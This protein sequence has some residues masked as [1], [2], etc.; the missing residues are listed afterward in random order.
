M[1]AFTTLIFAPSL[2]SYALKNISNKWSKALLSLIVPLTRLCAIIAFFMG[3]SFVSLKSLSWLSIRLQPYLEAL[4]QWFSLGSVYPPVTF[5]ELVLK[6]VVAGLL[7]GIIC[8]NFFQWHPQDRQQNLT[9]VSATACCGLGIYFVAKD[10]FYFCQ[11]ATKIWKTEVGTFFLKSVLGRTS[12]LI[13]CTKALSNIEE[14]PY[15]MYFYFFFV[16]VF[17]VYSLAFT[18]T[19]N[20][21]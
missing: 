11:I 6:C 10:T 3:S 5:M 20:I 15:T 21:F 18:A 4:L 2:L 7:A 13:G 19:P 8:R 12:I 17:Q 9:A 16:C 1:V 14:L